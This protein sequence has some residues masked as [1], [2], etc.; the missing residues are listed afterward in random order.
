MR[1][2]AFILGLILAASG[3]FLWVWPTYTD[4]EH[5]VEPGMALIVENNPPLAVFTS[6]I[7]YWAGWTSPTSINV[8][9]YDCGTTSAC[10]G[11]L[12]VIAKGGGVSGGFGWAG[13]KGEWYEIIPTGEAQIGVSY[14][15]P[16]AAGLA[17]LPLFAVGAVLALYAAFAGPARKS[18]PGPSSSVSPRPAA[19]RSGVNPAVL[20]PVRPATPMKPPGPTPPPGALPPQAP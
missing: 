4:I 7:S 3:A 1:W 15:E 13:P 20:P 11:H 10:Q 6:T 9:V 14:A 19:P 5:T 2:V 16:Y 8:T 18:P 17:G 12:P